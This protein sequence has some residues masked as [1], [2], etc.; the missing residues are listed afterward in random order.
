MRIS[1]FWIVNVVAGMAYCL[2]ALRS[3][4]SR[5]SIG[6]AACWLLSSTLA[7]AS[8]AEWGM[9]DP[10]PPVDYLTMLIGG[11]VWS[12]LPFA[13]ASLSVSLTDGR[14]ES[15]VKRYCISLIVL[16]LAMPIGVTAAAMTYM[17]ITD[18]WL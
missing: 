9:R 2:V 18:N 8:L 17:A 7:A 4:Q 16:T 6:L 13:L 15:M 12:G 11:F 1:L 10:R 5:G 3:Y 14:V